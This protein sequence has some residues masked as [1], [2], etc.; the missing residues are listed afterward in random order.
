VALGGGPSSNGKNISVDP[1]RIAT[2]LADLCDDVK[3]QLEFASYPLDE[4]AAR[5]S[6]RL[7][8]IH[9][10]PNGNG[11]LS[12]T[13]ADLLLVERGAPRF[14]WNAANLVTENTT[15][16]AYLSALRMADA[17]DYKPLLAFVR[18]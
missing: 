12:R 16:L 10:F 15:R 18:T 17:N 7:V 4:I 6:H 13:A 9:P 11:R 5:F 8:S 1:L 2:G 14:T 3:A